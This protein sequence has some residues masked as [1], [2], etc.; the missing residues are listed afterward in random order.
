M[1]R[2]GGDANHADFAYGHC[3]EK[4]WF[5]TP[6]ALLP[7]PGVIWEALGPNAEGFCIPFKVEAG[8]GFGTDGYFACFKAR[9]LAVRFIAYES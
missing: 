5:W 1:A 2:L 9:L 4:A 3:V 8:H 7:G 6:A